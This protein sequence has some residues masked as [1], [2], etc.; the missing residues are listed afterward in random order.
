M[1]YR[2]KE[3]IQMPI[4]ILKRCSTSLVKKKMQLTATMEHHFTYTRMTKIK[5]LTTP[6]ITKHSDDA[7]LED[8]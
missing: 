2:T 1:G 5:M 8:H 7:W 6:N 4:I 3:A